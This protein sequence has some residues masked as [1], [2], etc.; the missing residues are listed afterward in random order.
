MC[1]AAGSLVAEK[2]IEDCGSIHP[3]VAE[4]AAVV[5]GLIAREDSI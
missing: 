5:L 2:L 1:H 4:E 3:A